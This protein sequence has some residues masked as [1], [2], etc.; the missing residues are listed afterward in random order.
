MLYI[1]MG[2]TPERK[3]HSGDKFP[4]VP[5]RDVQSVQADGTELQIID[6]HIDG[7]PRSNASVEEWFGDHAKYIAGFLSGKFS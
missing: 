2:S 7:L 5:C 1:S 6:Q 3:W 4:D